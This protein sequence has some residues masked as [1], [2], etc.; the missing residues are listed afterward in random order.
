MFYG[1][2]PSFWDWE[3]R[4]FLY[5]GLTVL[6]GSALFLLSLVERE[7]ERGTA[8]TH[9]SLEERKPVAEESSRLGNED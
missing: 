5:S 6:P 4:A 3:G 9:L 1:V 2:F 8:E 7:R